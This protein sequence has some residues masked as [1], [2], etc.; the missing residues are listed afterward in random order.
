MNFKPSV[1][2]LSEVKCTHLER[3]LL[4]G[5]FSLTNCLFLPYFIIPVAPLSNEMGLCGIS[6]ILFQCYIRMSTQHFHR[7]TG[8][9]CP[10]VC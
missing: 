8:P 4:Y 1:M 3:V 6:E 2:Y 5:W 10:T 7:L 9:Y